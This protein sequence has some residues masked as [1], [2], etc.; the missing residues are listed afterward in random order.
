MALTESKMMALGTHV[1]DFNLPDTV[2]GLQR[3][4]ADIRGKAGTVVMFLCN[5]CPYVIHVN[6]ELVKIAHE[7]SDK[8]IGFVAISSNDAVKYPEDAP[9]KMSIVAKVLRYPFPYLYDESQEVARS[10]DAACTP[11]FYLF[12]GN[13]KLYYRGRLDASRPGNEYPLNGKDLREALNALLAGRPAPEK[14]Y[15]SAGCNIKWK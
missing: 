3:S 5:H 7:Y 9:D 2:T 10:Y 12:D 11:D 14:Q 8:G 4:Y 13:D 6:S 15:P 1:P